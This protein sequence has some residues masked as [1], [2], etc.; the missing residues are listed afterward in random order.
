MEDGG[1]KTFR[2]DVFLSYS[3][4][5]EDFV[6]T[7]YTR[8]ERDGI[9]CFFDQESVEWGENWVLALDQALDDCRW[10]VLVLSPAFLESGWTAEQWSAVMA[11]DRERILPILRADCDE[12][13]AFLRTIRHLPCR[14]DDEF[15]AAYAIMARKLRPAPSELDASSHACRGS[16]A[17]VLTEALASLEQGHY[18]ALIGPRGYGGREWLEALV[19]LWVQCHPR[20]KAVILHPAC[21]SVDVGNF[22]RQIALDVV[23]AL[24]EAEVTEADQEQALAVQRP[25]HLVELLKELVEHMEDGTG[26]LLLAVRRMGDFGPEHEA[27]L[28]GVLAQLYEDRSN[29]YACRRI[30][31]AA[32]GGH[33]LV[34]LMHGERK[35][36]DQLSSFN[37]PVE[38]E[39]VP[40]D[41]S[42]ACARLG[43][44][45]G[46][47]IWRLTGG[48]PALIDEIEAWDERQ[49]QDLRREEPELRAEV[50]ALQSPFLHRMLREAEARPGLANRLRKLDREGSLRRKLRDSEL[51]WS[52]WV[53]AEGVRRWV[54]AAPVF[55]VLV[56]ELAEAGDE[57][58]S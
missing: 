43:E 11:M 41:L 31:V 52:G 1:S 45:R 54:I 9:S 27:I 58:C 18:I 30:Q 4:H 48:H 24:A 19:T 20:R 38:H 2:R 46:E 6:R 14:D 5:D 50:I 3:R 42:E 12:L 40:M 21:V 32:S 8:F 33:G 29:S 44:E 17:Q 57:G 15:E 37:M 23:Q 39:L 35:P 28:A 34:Q 7:L 56:E 53:R 47:E 36:S 13:P 25:L 51:Q 26:E 10:L 16:R 55:Q 49:W 22:L